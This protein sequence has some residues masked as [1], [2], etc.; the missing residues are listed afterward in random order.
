MKIHF[1]NMTHID[2][3]KRTKQV[4]HPILRLLLIISWLITSSITT[5]PTPLLQAKEHTKSLQILQ[6]TIAGSNPAFSKTPSDST[7]ITLTPESIG[8]IALEDL[9]AASVASWG[10]TAKEL[11]TPRSGMQVIS[12]NYGSIYTFG[13]RDQNDQPSNVVEA[14]V[15]AEGKWYCSYGDIAAYCDFYTLPPL[16][17]PRSNMAIAAVWNN[18]YFFLIGGQSN[19]GH[20]VNIVEV[21]DTQ[22]NLWYC[23]YGDQACPIELQVIQPLPT[24]RAFAAGVTGPDGAIYVFGG[25]DNNGTLST[26]VEV[27]EPTNQQ[28]F[29]RAGMPTAR[30]AL[31]AAVDVIFGQIYLVGGIANLQTL[32]PVA[33]VEA[34]DVYNDRWYCSTLKNSCDNQYQPSPLSTPRSDLAIISGPDGKLYAI[35]G[36]NK[37]Q[38]F[39]TV[40]AYD[41]QT[42]TWENSEALPTAR[43]D[44]SAIVSTQDGL[45]YVLGG[46]SDV[47]SSSVSGTINTYQVAPPPPPDVTQIQQQAYPSSF[48]PWS[49]SLLALSERYEGHP[50]HTI[51]GNYTRQDI[52]LSMPGYGPEVRITR[53]YNSAYPRR[54]YFGWGWNSTFEMSVTDKGAIVEVKRNDGR[55]DSYTKQNGTLIPPTGSVDT[56]VRNGDGTYTLNTRQHLIYHFNGQGLLQTL[57]DA[58]DNR[59]T[60][61]YSGTQ[62]TAI[63]D[64]SGRRWTIT[65]NDQGLISQIVNPAR[66]I[67]SYTYNDLGELSGVTDTANG[68]MSYV[69]DELGYHQLLSVWDANNH[70]LEGNLYHGAFDSTSGQLYTWVVKQWDGRT[71]TEANCADDKQHK[72]YY[73]DGATL[74]VDPIGAATWSIYD[75]NLHLRYK[76]DPLNHVRQFDYSNGQLVN[77]E[78]DG[79]GGITD[80]TYDVRGNL[81]EINDPLVQIT[82]MEYDK[83]DNLIRRVDPRG[84]ETTW[85]YDDKDHLLSMTDAVGA[86]TTYNYDTHGQRTSVT[87]A[88]GNTTR[89][90][91]D[92]HGN[93][94][95]ITDGLGNVTRF[96][97][98][99]TGLVETK[100]DALGHKTTTTYNARNQP[101]SITAPDG[102][103]TRSTYDAVG[104][105][106]T[107]TDPL[108]N[109][110]TMGYN[111]ANDLVSTTDALGNTITY[112][113]DRLG[114]ET[115]RVLPD[116]GQWTTGYDANGRK[117]WQASPLCNQKQEC[118]NDPLLYCAGNATDCHVSAFSY[119]AAGNLTQ[120]TNAAGH[121]TSYRYDLNNQL[122]GVTDALG[123]ETSYERNAT[124]DLT[125]IVDANGS[126]TVYLYDGLHRRVAEMNPLFA[127]QET[128]TY[129][130]LG[131]IS[132]TTNGANETVS[133]TYDALGRLLSI[134][135]T[136]INIHFTYDAV[137]NRLSM[138]DG[139]GTTTYTYDANNRLTEVNGPNGKVSYS[140][141]KAGNRKSLQQ[142][143]SET[144]SYQYDNLNRIEQLKLGTSAIVSYGYDNGGRLESQSYGNGVTTT[145]SYDLAGRLIRQVTGT[146]NWELQRIEYTLDPL[147]NR[148]AESG[149]NFNATYSYDQLNQL[150]GATIA[151]FNLPTATPTKQP[152]PTATSTPR[153]TPTRTVTATPTKLNDNPTP[154]T[155]THIVVLPLIINNSIGNG[156]KQSVDENI[157][158]APTASEQMQPQQTPTPQPYMIA[159]PF[160]ANSPNNSSDHT[161]EQQEETFSSAAN[162][163]SDVVAH[164]P[165]ATS[166]SHAYA[167][168][169]DAVGNRLEFT[170]DGV[171]T[172]YSYDAANRMIAAGTRIITYD[173][174]GRLT[175]DGIY[176]YGYDALDRLDF[177]N[178]EQI[179]TFSYD[180]DDNRIAENRGGSIETYLLDTA[181]SLQVRIATT[182]DGDTE[183]YLYG[184]ERVLTIKQDGVTYHYEHSDGLGNIRMHTNQIGAILDISVYAPT[185]ERLS[186]DGAFGFTGEP[187]FAGNS[188][189]HL[190]ARDYHPALGRFLTIDPYE[191]DVM[192]PRTFN[193]YG[194]VLNNPVNL[195]DHTG[196][197]PCIIG[198]FNFCALG[199]SSMSSWQQPSY[200]P[201][202]PLYQQDLSPYFVQQPWQNLHLQGGNNF[203]VQPTTI[204]NPYYSGVPLNQIPITLQQQSAPL[205]D[206]LAQN[207][208][209]PIAERHPIGTINSF[210]YDFLSQMNNTYSNPGAMQRLEG[211]VLSLENW[212][213]VMRSINNSNAL[214]WADQSTLDAISGI[215]PNLWYYGYLP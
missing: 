155:F 177:L 209:G 35:G 37:A 215:D 113:Y 123:N 51:F 138:K 127:V 32:N 205:I 48:L 97:Y 145:S 9:T 180:G 157:V 93:L 14:Y 131:R 49:Q 129:D 121:T 195:A 50:T 168:R 52:D 199:G 171:T 54:G 136:D 101:L 146:A 115:S 91:Y 15:P 114:R 98:Y 17:T 73:F 25:I 198:G 151:Y 34:Y 56:L 74:Y 176:S 210:N 164:S 59:V 47:A 125:A 150:V 175:N 30:V 1:L 24:A 86:V 211:Q 212:N 189:V 95:A 104:N 169:Y 92:T 203:V 134:T 13:G 83:R 62:W 63:R 194:Y 77:R 178:A 22:E 120:V 3:A 108:G 67:V 55:I 45:I 71:C 106:L 85:V 57:K 82:K 111:E 130:V 167:Y 128:T 60:L 187:Y 170:E 78:I 110:T 193:L 18:R 158:P 79:N 143:G 27:W 153:A 69:Y 174:A 172:H 190:R 185:G 116:T 100:T 149:S 38:I 126:R 72:F 6:Q 173:A 147:G 88:L 94:T 87:D 162:S 2:R 4:I 206:L 66:Q 204:F 166:G 192:E 207:P 197:N 144:V 154:A 41:S 183:H 84:Y 124:S 213:G 208:L 29:A 44:H 36:A 179:S 64:A 139:T 112:S 76:I 159:L 102:G 70:L 202:V 107:A 58:D 61:E 23:S 118:A 201:Q 46:Q 40:E 31:G 165:S 19:V 135:A 99:E 163:K 105:Q 89:Y 65:Y 11:P 214:G 10:T 132:S 181:A 81:L 156:N 182:L 200:Q 90:Q 16:P 184:N 21:Y 122:T 80:Y 42:N 43:A 148:I 20:V 141:D 53:T 7:N 142:P 133:R 8:G 191:P 39:T 188:L 117:Q 75:T 103:I 109:I 160:V 140:Y 161:T 12:D 28:W 186:G 119:D 5:I 68:V 26:V 96:T 196:K 33:T 152:S 137:G